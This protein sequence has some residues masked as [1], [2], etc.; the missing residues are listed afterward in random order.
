MHRPRLLPVLPVALALFWLSPSPG[1]ADAASG[2]RL[3]QKWCAGCHVINGEGPPAVT[4]HGPRSF[5][6]IAQYLE[7]EPMRAFLSRP[8]GQM[9]DLALT[10]AEIDDL[11]AYIGTLR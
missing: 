6:A 10:R 5:S 7:P 2:H 11:T 4:P 3:A 1:L 9:P 8:H